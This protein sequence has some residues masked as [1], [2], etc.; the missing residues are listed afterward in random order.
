MTPTPG[1]GGRPVNLRRIAFTAAG[2]AV[3]VGAFLIG[4]GLA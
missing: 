1:R 3:I 2:L 4:S